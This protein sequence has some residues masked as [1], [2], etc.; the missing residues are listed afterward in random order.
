MKSSTIIRVGVLTVI[1]VVPSENAAGQ[2][3]HTNGSSSLETI[4]SVPPLQMVNSILISPNGKAV[5]T[6]RGEDASWN[7]IDKPLTLELWSVPKGK[8]LWKAKERAFSLLAFSP[9]STRLAGIAEKAGAVLWDTGNGKVKSRFRPRTVPFS[10]AAFLPDGRTLV[11]AASWPTRTSL[12]DAGEIQLWKAKTGH[13]ISTPKAQTNA[14]SALAISPDGR[15]LAVA[16]QA[17]GVANTVVL[18]DIAIDSIRYRMELGTNVF[19]IPSLAFSPDGKTLAAGTGT[20]DGKGEVRLWDVASGKLKRTVTG[21][22]VGAIPMS[23]DCSVAFF[24]DGAMLAIIG[25]NQTI[26]LWSVSDNKWR[27]SFG[28]SDPPDPGR[29]V[30]QNVPEGLLLA[31]VNRFQ[32]VEVKLWNYNGK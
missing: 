7:T 18:L 10:V 27:G 13:F 19:M 32:Q 16:N 2:P 22:D 8:L 6:L 21:A 24:S 14:M 9:D 3:P 1:L 11:T 17:N 5:A 23:W 25:E 29:Y 31:G 15:T 26:N 30:I 4:A 20:H 12:P 28:Y